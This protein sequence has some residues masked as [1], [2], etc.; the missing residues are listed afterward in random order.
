MIRIGS[1]SDET[2]LWYS[3]EADWKNVE[4]HPI[5]VWQ[6]CVIQTEEYNDFIGLIK[7]EINSDIE[8]IGSF[9][10]ADDLSMFVFV[11]KTN[12]PQFSLWRFNLPG[13]RW[14]FDAFWKINGGRIANDS[15]ILPII[16]KLGLVINGKSPLIATQKAF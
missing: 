13:I 9:Q 10:T 1:H 14:W 15:E 5:A 6:G 16:N 11:V 3:E 12:V 8:P 4:G 7:K 2:A